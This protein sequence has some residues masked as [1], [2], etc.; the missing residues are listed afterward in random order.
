MLNKR[1]FIRSSAGI[2]F[3][4]FSLQLESEEFTYKFQWLSLPVASLSIEFDDI[5][6][7]NND[8]GSRT[9]NFKLTTKGPL[10]L[11]REY[12]SQGY[13]K[14]DA[15]ISWDYYLSGNDRGQPEEKHITYFYNMAPKIRKFIDDIGVSP[16]NIDSRLDKNAIDPFS[17]L[18]R[19]IDQLKSEQ[20]CKNE[21]IIMDGKRRYKII[22]NLEEKIVDLDKEMNEAQNIIYF[23]KFTFSY[24]REE[25]RKWPFNK[26]NRYLDV[27][28]SSKLGYKPT[29]FYTKTPIGS[30]VGDYVIDRQR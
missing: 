25:K 16:I 3:I 29:R 4:L 30:I 28:F 9:T 19:T 11:Y 5:A 27:W 26:K 17:V 12:N 18:F 7:D 14:Y 8:I 23:C 22:V 1:Y 21:F 2:F 20:Q 6:Y 13:I 15:D 10:R 24:L